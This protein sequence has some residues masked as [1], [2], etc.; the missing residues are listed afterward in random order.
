M[1]SDSCW[2]DATHSKL[3]R[4]M[5]CCLQLTPAWSLW[6]WISDLDR[7]SHRPL[8]G[9][10]SWTAE[11]R[12]SDSLSDHMLVRWA[13]GSLW[14][15]TI[16]SLMWLEC[17]RNSW[18][19][20][21]LMLLTGF[22]RSSDPGWNPVP[23]G[24]QTSYLPLSCGTTDCPSDWCSDPGLGG[25]L[26]WDFSITSMTCSKNIFF[27][28]VIH[29]YFQTAKTRSTWSQCISRSVQKLATVFLLLLSVFLWCVFMLTQRG[30]IK[31]PLKASIENL[32]YWTW[33]WC[34][35]FFFFIH[36][37]VH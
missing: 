25:D 31:G 20:K 6:S 9:S 4:R 27:L 10:S 15:V 30:N 3:L 5:F 26:G 1:S 29:I 18:M 34:L 21:A 32:S 35:I 13:V 7:P 28:L 8:C 33:K 24:Q 14:C 23:L 19:M 12:S 22:A 36:S 11:V 16:S 17:V 2:A 37:Q